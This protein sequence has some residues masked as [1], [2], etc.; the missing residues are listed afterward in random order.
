MSASW[1]VGTCILSQTDRYRADWS[2][3]EPGASSRGSLRM[4]SGPSG[5]GLKDHPGSSNNALSEE[6][7]EADNASERFSRLVTNRLQQYLGST[8]SDGSSFRALRKFLF[9]EGK[10]GEDLLSTSRRSSG[11]G[12]PSSAHSRWLR[13]VLRPLDKLRLR[14]GLTRVVFSILCCLLVLGLWDVWRSMTHS[15]SHLS[16]LDH[17]HRPSLHNFY[18]REDDRLP[19]AVQPVSPDV[20]AVLLNWKRPDNLAVLVK[21]ICAMSFV[22][23]ILIYNVR[24]TV[25]FSVYLEI[26][27]LTPRCV[28]QPLHLPHPR[29][30]RNSRM[31]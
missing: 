8:F 6:D 4:S 13:Q 31:S 25:R 18:L 1:S 26:T 3:T 2:G 16:S 15:A 17:H 10:T 5:S 11:T 22:H 9:V 29:T 28:E 7:S 12:N 21:Q 14:L 20:T 23:H 27:V 30:S 24:S 19:R